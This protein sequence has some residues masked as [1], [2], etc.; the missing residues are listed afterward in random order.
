MEQTQANIHKRAPGTR[1]QRSEINPRIK[2]GLKRSLEDV[3]ETWE[4][5][6]RVEMRTGEQKEDCWEHW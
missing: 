3:A 4:M 5:E 2:L 1:N 6:E